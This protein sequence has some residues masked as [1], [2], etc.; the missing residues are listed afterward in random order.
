MTLFIFAV[1][2]LI[3]GAIIFSVT[4]VTSSKFGANGATQLVSSKQTVGVPA[5]AA[6]GALMGNQTV[7]S[8]DQTSAATAQSEADKL[9]DYILICASCGGGP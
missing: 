8:A 7:A 2:I 1:A 9:K 5:K 4:A 6:S 3:A